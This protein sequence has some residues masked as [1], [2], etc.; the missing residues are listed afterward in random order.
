[1]CDS[2]ISTMNGVVFTLCIHFHVLILI[3][4]YL[5]AVDVFIGNHLMCANFVRLIPPLISQ[6]WSTNHP[7][8]PLLVVVTFLLKLQLQ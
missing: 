3:C 8:C 2:L 5:F 1:M 4:M 6:I 7:L